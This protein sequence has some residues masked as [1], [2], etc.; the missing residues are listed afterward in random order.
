MCLNRQLLTRALAFAALVAI[1]ACQDSIAPIRTVQPP[2]FSPT[3]FDGAHGGNKAVFFL[4]PMVSNPNGQPGFGDPVKSGLPVSFKIERLP[5]ATLGCTSEVTKVFSTSDVQFSTDFYQANWHTDESNLLT[6]C[7]Y[8]IEVLIGTQIEAFADVD[9]VS[10]GSQLKRVDTREFIPLLDGRTLPIKVRV[11]QG[12]R[13]CTDPSCVSTIVPRNT[14][15]LVVTPNLQNAAQFPPN[16]FDPQQVGTDQVV[17]TI[18]DI[19]SQVNVP[20]GPGCSL[21]LTKMASPGAH[22]IRFT[23]DPE[24]EHITAEVVVAVC[25]E[26]RGDLPQM[27][28]KYDVGEAPKFLRNVPAPIVCPEAHIGSTTKMGQVMQYASA[29]LSHIG[30]AVQSVFGP[31][32]LNAFD[33]G[34]GGSLGIGDGFSVIAAGHPVGM[35]KQEGDNQSGPAGQ[36]LGDSPTVQLRYLHRT[37]DTQPAGPNDAVVTCTVIGN[38]G[39][40]VDE[41]DI[42]QG[43]AFHDSET[44]DDGVYHCPSWRPGSG[45]NVIEVTANILDDVV[46]VG[47]QEGQF[48]GKVQ[49]HAFGTVPGGDDIVV[50]GD[51]NIFGDTAAADPNNQQ[52]FRNLVNFRT[53][54]TR[55]TGTHVRI[56]CSH[57]PALYCSP[58]NTFTATMAAAGY[59]VDAGRTLSPPIPANVKLYVISPPTQTFTQAELAALSQFAS[60]GGRIVLLAESVTDDRVGQLAALNSVRAGL[61]LPPQTLD[62][63]GPSVFGCS[64]QDGSNFTVVPGSQMTSTAI[65]AGLKQLTVSCGSQVSWGGTALFTVSDGEVLHTMA[66]VI[67]LAPVIE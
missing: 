46:I 44:D 16:W 9:V 57:G 37:S 4:P 20:G 6:Q 61:F 15:T 24:V 42:L 18:E 25:Q 45:D 55:S 17:V 21:G 49:F 30:R 12:V 23:T 3:I 52:L 39:H 62:A 48:A 5:D 47:G 26:D 53:Q 28:L 54:A 60:E 35:F 13:F 29:A 14:T 38:N 11:E 43:Q 8:R 1:G 58:S 34:V 66:A 32:A 2:Q 33:L 40:L 64:G 31:R 59:T 22:C 63:F 56:D 65:M 10:S 36:I 7:T 51:A 67:S 41:G 27:L 19:S 50:F